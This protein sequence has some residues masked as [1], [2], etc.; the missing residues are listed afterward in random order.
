MGRRLDQALGLSPEPLSP[1]GE[2]PM[3]RVRLCFAE[4][5]AE[6]ADLVRAIERLAADLARRLER[7]GSGARRLDLAFHRIDGRV[8]HIRLGTARPTRD[9]RHLA[10]LFAARLET[11]DPGLGVEDM[12]LGVFAAEPLGAEQSQMSPAPPLRDEGVRGVSAASSESAPLTLLSLPN[13]GRGFIRGAERQGRLAA[14][15]DRIGARLD[16]NAIGFIAARDSHIPERASR[17]APIADTATDQSSGNGRSPWRPIR[18]FSPPQPIEAVWV[19][20]D[21]PPFRFTWRRRTHRVC[22]AAGPERIA[23]EWWAEERWAEERWADTGSAAVDAVRDYY[24]V[25]D[26]AG[27]RFWLF[28]AGL[29]GYSPPRWY[30]HGVFP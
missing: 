16:L 28:R 8:E 11:I 20:P 5:I 10:A 17:F 29:P 21:D 26:E 30:I 12:I 27:R 2:A 24:R 22:R 15:L 3:R 13:G 18:L 19:L 6:P 25:E 23:E 1:L 9:P 7:E 4:P 14:L